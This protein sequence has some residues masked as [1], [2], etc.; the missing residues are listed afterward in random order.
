[1]KKEITHSKLK[2]KIIQYQE[3]INKTGD[4]NT[5]M[6]SYRKKKYE[7]ENARKTKN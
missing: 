2:N 5:K 3:K 6:E 7:N 4:E 1:M